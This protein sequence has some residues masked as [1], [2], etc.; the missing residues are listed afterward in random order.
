MRCPQRLTNC[1][2]VGDIQ[3]ARLGTPSVGTG[4]ITSN[5]TRKTNKKDE[6]EAETSKVTSWIN[7]LSF[8]SKTKTRAQQL[9]NTREFAQPLLPDEEASNSIK[10]KS[11]DGQDSTD[12]TYIPPTLPS[13]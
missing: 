5:T 10:N 9:S 1:K 7:S 8:K 3:K 13:S 12:S 2:I 11:K 4:A 6:E